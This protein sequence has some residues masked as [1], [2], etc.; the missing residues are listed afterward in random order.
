LTKNTSTN[1][2][3]GGSLIK[4]TNIELNTHNLGITQYIGSDLKL[5][6]ITGEQGGSYVN[7]GVL[8][9]VLLIMIY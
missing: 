6:D 8:E 5:F 1:F 3:L 9:K 2:Q 4:D 7:I